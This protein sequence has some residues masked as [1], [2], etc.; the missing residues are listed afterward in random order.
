MFLANVLKFM[1]FFTNFGRGEFEQGSR[2][3]RAGFEESNFAILFTS[4]HFSCFYVFLANLQKFMICSQIL[5]EESSSR[6]RARFEQLERSPILR[7]VSR[8]FHFFVVWS[9]SRF[10]T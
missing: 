6:V 10:S 2:K 9:V 1:I 7:F 5:A 8:F 3:V 4:F